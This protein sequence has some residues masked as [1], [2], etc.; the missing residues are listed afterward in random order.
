[1]RAVRFQGHRRLSGCMGSIPSSVQPS[2]PATNAVKTRQV[3]VH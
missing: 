3:P 1:V 2:P